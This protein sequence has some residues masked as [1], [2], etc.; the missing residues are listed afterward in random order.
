MHALQTSGRSAMK[1]RFIVLFASMVLSPLTL[2]AADSTGPAGKV[3]IE[4]PDDVFVLEVMARNGK[5]EPNSTLITL[6]SPTLAYWRINLESQK[7]QLDISE[8]KYTDGRATERVL[9]LKAKAKALLDASNASKDLANYLEG[10]RK[11]GTIGL[12]DLEQ[13]R[14][15]ANVDLSAAI[16]AGFTTKQ[17]ERRQRDDQDKIAAQRAK[18]AQEE[19]LLGQLTERLTIKTSGGGVFTSHVVAGTF[20]KKGHTLGELRN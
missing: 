9:M 2:V 12:Q 5:V 16:E 14:K 4:A 11:A 19:Q 13:A 8:R 10:A 17:E 1:L 6:Q 7:R 3:D 18:M 15:E 20:V